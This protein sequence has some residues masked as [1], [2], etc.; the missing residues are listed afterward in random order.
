MKCVGGVRQA[1]L[2]PVVIVVFVGAG[3]HYGTAAEHARKERTAMGVC[4]YRN[5]FNS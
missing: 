4:S 5:T 2:G 3:V 1:V